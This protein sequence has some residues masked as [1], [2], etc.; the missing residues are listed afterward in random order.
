MKTQSTKKE[1]KFYIA[2]TMKDARKKVEGTLKDYD[3]KFVKVQ[4]KNGRAFF[5]ELKANPIK[6]V[7]NLIDENRGIITKTRTRR[8]ELWKKTVENIKEENF[9]ANTRKKF[10]EYQTHR[11]NIYKG[12]GSDAKIVMDDL[13]EMGKKNMKK[14]AIKGKIEKRFAKRVNS[15][16]STLNIPSKD[17]VESLLAEV[18]TV[19]KKVDAL[20]KDFPR[21]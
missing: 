10:N 15:I 5:T 19:T 2:N 1:S 12:I 21:A 17:Q 14:S 7:G 6:K 4:L 11:K 20:G 9:K 8:L 13:K 18:K 16:Y 3:E